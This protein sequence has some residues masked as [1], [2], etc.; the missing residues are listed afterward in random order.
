M[1]KRIFRLQDNAYFIRKR[2]Y[3]LAM[4]C[5]QDRGTVGD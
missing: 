2:E 5:V 1:L 3:H 4:L